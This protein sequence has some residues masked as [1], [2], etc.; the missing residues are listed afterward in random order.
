MINANYKCYYKCISFHNL[1]IT[2][3]I[4]VKKEQLCKLVVWIYKA[5]WLQ[6]LHCVLCVF[7]NP[8][9]LSG[10]TKQ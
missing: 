5:L 8:H 4:V 1:T 6:D 9:G 7:G 10:I 2:I 3:V